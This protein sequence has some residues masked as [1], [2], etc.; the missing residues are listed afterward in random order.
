MD[1]EEAEKLLSLGYRGVHTVMAYSKPQTGMINRSSRYS[2]KDQAVYLFPGTVSS[3]GSVIGYAPATRGFS[4]YTLEHLR[5]VKAVSG[6]REKQEKLEHELESITAFLCD[7]EEYWSE[8]ENDYYKTLVGNHVKNL[9]RKQPVSDDRYRV[10]VA[11][12]KKLKQIKD[13]PIL[14]YLLEMLRD[15]QHLCKISYSMER[16]DQTIENFVTRCK[17]VPNI[18]RAQLTKLRDQFKQQCKQSVD[19]YAALSTIGRAKIVAQ[20]MLID[21]VVTQRELFTYDEIIAA[22]EEYRP[23]IAVNVFPG[24]LR[25]NIYRGVRKLIDDC[26]LE[27]NVTLNTYSLTPRCRAMMLQLM[28]IDNEWAKK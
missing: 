11:V 10:T 17:G 19:D 23:D 20:V 26:F 6:F 25:L 2:R 3:D 18:E 16:R 24:T 5:F 7:L 8:I 27:Q 12:V 15:Y 13:S 22:F 28:D 9:L 4:V 21:E 1:R 14:D